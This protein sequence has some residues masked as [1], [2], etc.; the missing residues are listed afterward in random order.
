MTP[1]QQYCAYLAAFLSLIG[2][3]GLLGYAVEPRIFVVPVLVAF[4]VVAIWTIAFSCRK[5][6]TPYLYEIKGGVI[7]PKFL[8]K[9]CRQCG[10]PTNLR[11]VEKD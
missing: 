11:Y 6:G 8:P 5:C 10:W 3:G 2:T 7:F 9:K 4:C 1:K